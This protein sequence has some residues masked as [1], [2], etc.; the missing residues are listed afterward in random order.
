MEFVL[1]HEVVHVDCEGHFAFSIRTSHDCRDVFQGKDGGPAGVD[2]CVHVLEARKGQEEVSELHGEN[3][4]MNNSMP[5][6]LCLYNPP[7]ATR[8]Y[9]ILVSMQYNICQL[10]GMALFDHLPSSFNE[11]GDCFF[12]QNTTSTL[13]CR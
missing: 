12:T 3:S 4:T 5:I 1:G 2:G 8:A 6:T 13:C 9:Q 10:D 7:S 11:T